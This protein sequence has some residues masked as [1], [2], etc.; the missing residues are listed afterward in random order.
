MQITAPVKA[1]TGYLDSL[2]I[3]PG[4]VYSLGGNIRVIYRASYLQ[5]FAGEHTVC[6]AGILFPD[7]SEWWP[8]HVSS[9]S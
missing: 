7:G 9:D 2:A 5:Y 8:L 4:K 3:H 1:D 6:I